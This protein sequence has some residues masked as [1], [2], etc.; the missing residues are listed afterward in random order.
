MTIAVTDISVETLHQTFE[1]I[2]TIVGRIAKAKPDLTKT[3]DLEA[4][5][6]DID[7][8]SRRA[9][10]NHRTRLSDDYLSELAGILDPFELGLAD[11]EVQF[12]K[13][14]KATPSETTSS[15]RDREIKTPSSG[16]TMLVT[17]KNAFEEMMKTAGKSKTPSS[18]QTSTSTKLVKK[19]VV[20]SSK[21]TDVI[22][23]DDDD[24]DDSFL[25][26][27]SGGDLDMIEKKAKVASTMPKPVFPRSGFPVRHTPTAAAQKLNINVVPRK[28]IPPKPSAPSFKSKFMQEARR[29]HKMG[30]AER[31][32][33]QIG[34]INPV[35]PAGSRLG[36]GLGAHTGEPRKIKM[37]ES[38]SSATDSSDEDNTGMKALAQRQ[39]S[40][41]KR[42]PI[43]PHKIKMMGSAMDDVLR[44]REERRNAQ[45]RIK[46]RLRPD[47]SDLH[48][49]ILSWDPQHV[50][51]TPPHH[52]QYAALTSKLGPVPPTFPSAKQYEQTML[53][54]FLQELWS[55]SQQER[56]SM[57][58]PVVIEVSARQYD[59]G[60]VD[61]DVFS[62][63]M[64]GNFVNESD[65]VVLSQPGQS[66][67]V[68]A[69][70]QAF[71]KKQ[72]IA[73][74]KLRVSTLMDKNLVV[75]K[76]VWHMMKHFS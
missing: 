76:T 35:L 38:E 29:E 71:K 9:D 61:I 49:Y 27:L 22:D 74:I 30:I 41:V 42:A 10:A 62:K 65:V 6:Q 53:P 47:I 70:V 73:Q 23:I 34:G 75:P 48:R 44:V 15:S 55:Q 28:P 43:V 40:P 2:K 58:S 36:T 46:Q 18:S 12:L 37:I 68:L 8:F 57:D 60:F 72:N 66:S 20:S 13:E 52:P 54:L 21:P 17:K 7:K 24:F 45:H 64:Y 69:K 14:Q 16:E 67:R 25:D 11:D 56:P 31:G 32:R 51:P 39:K 50:G 3:P 63:Q 5:L 4:T 1:L 26:Q 19:A 59:D 33:A